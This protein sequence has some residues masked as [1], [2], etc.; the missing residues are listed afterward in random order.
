MTNTQ[1]KKFY[2]FIF[3]FFFLSGATGLVY[4]V[5]WAKYLSNIFGSTAYAHTI[6]LAVFMGGLAYG[7]YLLGRIADRFK[8]N[9]LYLYGVIE[10]IIG[11]YC[12]FYPNIANL[13]ETVYQNIAWHF[14]LSSTSKSLLA[15]QFFFN[16]VNIFIPTM[17]MGGTLPIMAKFI[18]H[19]KT[20]ILNKI[21]ILYFINS[22]GAVFGSL[23]C[24]F[25]LI[26]LWGLDTSI[27]VAASINVLI[28]FLSIGISKR[29][30]RVLGASDVTEQ[31]SSERDV[32]LEE[33]K[34][35]F[36][37]IIIFAIGM[38]GFVSML[39]EVMWIR[40]LTQLFGS[41]VY[42]FSLVV[43]AFIA[44]IS[45]G[46]WWLAK[47]AIK[48]KE[49]YY[50]FGVVQALIA[51]TMCFCVLSI[52]H[53]TEWVWFLYQTFNTREFVYPIF[54]FAKFFLVFLILLLPTFFIG[55]TLPLAGSICAK[56]L[57][58]LGRDVGNV[59]SIN[60]LGALFGTAIAGL[61]L[62][63]NI[64]ILNSFYIGILIN[65][66]LALILFLSLRQKKSLRNALG[67]F[68]VFISLLIFQPLSLDNNLM[69]T[70][71]FRYKAN[72]QINFSE[73][74]NLITNKRKILYYK[75]GLNGNVAVTKM[76]D[77]KTLFIN[78]K[79]DASSTGDMPTQLLS[80]H[81]PALLHKNPRKVLVI[82][83]GSGVTVG[84]LTRHSSIEQIDVLEISPAVI[85]A[86][87][88]FKEVNND[89]LNN[90]K[91][92]VIIDDAKNFLSINKEKYDLIIS[93]P[94][95]PWTAG[96]A[97]LLTV[98]S[99]KRIKKSLK[100]GG[101]IL[102][103]F[104]T[105]EM[106]NDLFRSIGASFTHVF[107]KVS[108]WQPANGDCF[109]IGSMEGIDGNP[110][111]MQTAIQ[112]NDEVKQSLRQIHA[113]N[114][115]SILSTQVLSAQKTYELFYRKALL[116]EDRYP[117]IEFNAP[118]AFFL[119]KRVTLLQE[120]D[121]RI[122]FDKANSLILSQFLSQKE[123]NNQDIMDV[124]HFMK[125]SRVSLVNPF[126]EHY[127]DTL[128]SMSEDKISEKL[129]LEIKK[130][131]QQSRI[132]M[133]ERLKELKTE[134]PNSYA[135]FQAYRKGL[136]HEY[137]VRRSI[138]FK[139]EEM[140]QE[141]EQLIL[142]GVNT[143]HEHKYELILQLADFFADQHEYEKSLEKYFEIIVS[144]AQNNTTEN[145]GVVKAALLR[146][147]DM[148]LKYNDVGSLVKVR[149]LAVK[150]FPDDE[151]LLRDIR[152][153]N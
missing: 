32:A 19:K 8:G 1:S 127:L 52:N 119:R 124:Y 29:G 147:K 64:G 150:I 81:L 41:S 59:F 80:G 145:K 92:N 13:L 107:P 136:Q 84:A 132:Q 15:L 130:N 141:I 83:F 7:N 57:K 35:S 75:E 149:E 103:W 68:V 139:N 117:I 101:I 133:L 26:R 73:Y 102:Q 60:T 125:T 50:F 94:T 113:D 104:H 86:G 17:L 96:T 44:G 70:S 72:G 140:Y 152:K 11:I 114:I 31:T 71:L 74:F 38:S 33:Y 115:Y 24:G 85:G 116:N 9:L 76:G 89:C 4:Q 120:A 144:G 123:L 131:E 49:K 53:F 42:S 97:S 63:P 108:V 10:L 16:S 148:S 2:F 40:T 87:K 88:F 110:F 151:R 65:L 20:E 91:V 34:P 45:L 90:K 126:L 105:Y 51:I 135:T 56:S 39:Y 58:I 28:G 138:F 93:E 100:E 5:I 37:K 134:N 23:L 69:L 21:S 54:L 61:I 6:V 48:I 98:E 109:F 106:S 14:H 18:T 112:Q 137:L 143:Y 77:Q 128:L 43:A 66:I 153:N 95:N 82:G 62:L 27:S 47:N 25:F 121:E 99:F 146:V 78:G 122:H 67:V 118:R 79:P 111:R 55:I 36:R 46:S 129:F 142:E 3:L 30:G 12:M 22:V